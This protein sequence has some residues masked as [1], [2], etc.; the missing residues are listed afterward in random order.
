[1]LVLALPGLRDLFHF[2]EIRFEDAALGIG[3]GVAGILGLELFDRVRRHAGRR[4]AR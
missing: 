3:A 2:S 1:M 4:L